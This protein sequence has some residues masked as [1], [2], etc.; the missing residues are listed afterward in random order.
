MS[1]RMIL[2]I[3]HIVKKEWTLITLSKK[4]IWL[5]FTLVIRDELSGNILLSTLLTINSSKSQSSFPILSCYN[6]LIIIFWFFIFLAQSII[7]YWLIDTLNLRLLLL[8]IIKIIIWITILI[9]IWINLLDT[10]NQLIY[11]RL[12][13]ILYLFNWFIHL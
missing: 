13:F 7:N 4:T 3:L 2:I 11:F 12:W 6:W 1:I 5:N 10:L 8:K 9:K